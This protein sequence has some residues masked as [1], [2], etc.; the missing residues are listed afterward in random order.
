MIKQL[1]LASY[2]DGRLDP[3]KTEKISSLLSRANLKAYIKALKRFE[4]QSTLYIEIP[5]GKQDDYKEI[6]ANM[7]PDKNIIF[8]S[9]PSLLLG[10]KIIDNDVIYDLSLKNNLVSLVQHLQ[11]IYD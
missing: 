11:H 5:F 7:F 2:T 6:F 1:V 3:K 9:N 10:L 4:D 8:I